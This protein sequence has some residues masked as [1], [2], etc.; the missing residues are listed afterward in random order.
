MRDEFCQ[1]VVIPVYNEQSTLNQVLKLPR[2]VRSNRAV[3]NLLT[4]L[5]FMDVRTGYKALWGRSS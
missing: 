4:S 1:S 3:L 5:S 2:S